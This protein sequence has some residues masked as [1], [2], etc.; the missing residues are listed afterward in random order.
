ME[1][2][3]KIKTS[4]NEENIMKLKEGIAKLE[5]SKVFKDFL[6]ENPDHYLA[7]AFMMYGTD[8]WQIGYYGKKEDKVVV[9]MVQEGEDVKRNPAEEVFKKPESKIKELNLED[10]K[11]DLEE[12]IGIADKLMKEKY[13][14]ENVTKTIVIVQN[15]DKVVYNLT[16]V[17][18]TFNIIN[19]KI[20]AG[21][22]EIISESKH[23][24]LGDLGYQVK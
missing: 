1:R 16:I 17:T 21:S 14:V 4:Q 8:E 9:F 11:I 18:H 23:S 20:N 19:V 12:A 5:G 3:K 6:D 7:H 13:P 10:V 15:L 22:G 2:S 24:I